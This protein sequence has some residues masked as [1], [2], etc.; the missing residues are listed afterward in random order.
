QPQTQL[1][2]EIA[3]Q[4]R[5]ASAGAFED[6]DFIE[7]FAE[8]PREFERFRRVLYGF[9]ARTVSDREAEHFEGGFVGGSMEIR[10]TGP[11]PAFDLPE[12][13]RRS[14][15]EI[16]QRRKHARRRA[17]IASHEGNAYAFHTRF[18]HQWVFPLRTRPTRRQGIS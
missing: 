18:V 1:R 7:A 10:L 13:F 3:R 15:A 8:H 2:A 6:E 17:I 16:E 5:D 14:R 4:R 11:D 9:N 12:S